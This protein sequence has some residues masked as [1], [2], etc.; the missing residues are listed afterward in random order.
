MEKDVMYVRNRTEIVEMMEKIYGLIKE[1][2]IDVVRG[3]VITDVLDWVI[4]DSD[5]LEQ[6]VEESEKHGI[7]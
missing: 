1:G 7:I 6:L 2:K 3:I 4:S 5:C